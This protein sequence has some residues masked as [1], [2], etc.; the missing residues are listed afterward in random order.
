VCD[1]SGDGKDEVVASGEESPAGAEDSSRPE[2]ALPRGVVV[3]R[4]AATFLPPFALFFATGVIIGWFDVRA[5]ARYFKA[6]CLGYRETAFLPNSS[7]NAG[8]GVALRFGGRAHWNVLGQE[9]LAVDSNRESVLWNT[10][11]RTD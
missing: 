5:A 11:T 4:A 10:W 2:S 6:P 3:E 7:R 1:L 9:T 8:V